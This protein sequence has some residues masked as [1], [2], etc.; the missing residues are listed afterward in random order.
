[1]LLKENLMVPTRVILLLLCV[2]TSVAERRLSFEKHYANQPDT[3]I[4][5][6]KAYTIAFIVAVMSI[7]A[8]WQ[9]C[10]RENVRATLAILIL[11][12]VANL[13]IMLTL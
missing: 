12:S 11:G 2:A 8:F 4:V 9:C 7:A 5:L 6:F 13:L 1:M 10:C 3:D